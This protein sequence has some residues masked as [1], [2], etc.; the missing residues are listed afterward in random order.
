MFLQGATSGTVCVCFWLSADDLAKM[1][2]SPGYGYKAN[3][4]GYV[5]GCGVCNAD[6]K[7]TLNKI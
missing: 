5:N 4:K 6:G 2:A 3:A 1:S 7:W